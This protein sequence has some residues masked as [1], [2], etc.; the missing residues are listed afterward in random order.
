MT[1]T[2]KATTAELH[3]LTQQCKED[4]LDMCERIDPDDVAEFIDLEQIGLVSPNQLR[5]IC[6]RANA[7]AYGE[8][9]ANLWETS[10]ADILKQ[11]ATDAHDWRVRMVE[12]YT[13][14][15]AG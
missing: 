13:K 8:L 1:I 10:D 4:A 14:Q 15:F 2:R 3:N 6:A 9:V 5:A 7:Y 11:G 12:F